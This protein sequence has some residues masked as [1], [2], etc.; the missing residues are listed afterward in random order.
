MFSLFLLLAR[1]LCPNQCAL[2]GEVP[3][4]RAGKKAG[5]N[6]SFIVT[7]AKAGVQS[8]MLCWRLR[9]WIPAFAGM[10][11]ILFFSA[12]FALSVVK[13]S[14]YYARSFRRVRSLRMTIN[15]RDKQRQTEN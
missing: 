14:F 3:S 15:N 13:I 2:G 9:H 8:Q 4:A 10:T 6:Y 11:L 1:F 12:L 7:P 5:W